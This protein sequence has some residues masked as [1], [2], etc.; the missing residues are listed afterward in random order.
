MALK[1]LRASKTSR[2]R[3]KSSR[4][5][6]K[7]SGRR[8]AADAVALSLTSWRAAALWELAAA[9]N[10][11]LERVVEELVDSALCRELSL[12]LDLSGERA[13]GDC[14]GECKDSGQQA[15]TT[16]HETCPDDCE[17][18]QEMQDL[19]DEAKA[20]AKRHATAKCRKLGKNC[21][22]EAGT[23]TQLD[24]YC[25]TWPAEPNAHPPQ[26]VICHRVARFEY[27]GTCTT[28]S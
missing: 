1:R 16:R 19:V 12:L 7:P 15:T 3:R 5:A 17:T 24:K 18:N 25:E 21:S 8:G 11:P 2:A 27:K 9:S 13:D 14:G 20:R 22:C 28:D 10:L 4:R 6:D 26:P 23:W